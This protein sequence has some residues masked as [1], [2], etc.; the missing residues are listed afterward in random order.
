MLSILVDMITKW[1]DACHGRREAKS[2]K[3]KVGT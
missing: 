2:G 3:S 1:I